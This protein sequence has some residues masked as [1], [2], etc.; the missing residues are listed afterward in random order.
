M[1]AKEL[2]KRI[3]ETIAKH[4]E[5]QNVFLYGASA[6]WEM[7]P[8]FVCDALVQSGVCTVEEIQLWADE[9]PR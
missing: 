9:A 8:N 2:A 6:G 4:A 3:V 1:E 5:R 7:D